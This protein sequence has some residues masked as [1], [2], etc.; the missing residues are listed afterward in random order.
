[1]KIFLQLLAAMNLM[2]LLACTSDDSDKDVIE[3][4]HPDF[5]ADS[6]FR[7]DRRFDYAKANAEGFEDIERGERELNNHRPVITVEDQGHKIV[8]E[9]PNHPHKA[10]HYWSWMQ[11]MDFSGNEAYSDVPLPEDDQESFTFT[12]FSEVRFKKR[13]RIRCYCQVH[14]EFVDYMEVPVFKKKTVLDRDLNP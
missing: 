4:R 7:I 9:F 10:K 2:A 14:G 3:P 6:E 13:I 8:L 12:L 5:R 1:M 11:V